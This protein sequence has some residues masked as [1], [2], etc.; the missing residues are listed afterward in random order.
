MQRLEELAKQ[1]PV[2]GFWKCY[3]R[4]RN[5]GTVVNHK[6]LHRVYQQMGLPLRRKIK[7][8]LPARVKEPLAIPACFTQTWSIDF[9]FRGWCI[10]HHRKLFL[11]V[12]RCPHRPGLPL[13]NF[14]ENG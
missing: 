4:I 9:S 13:E 11:P 10:F 6:K 8:R 3:G 7:K 14:A 5:S 12:V 1:N 2:E